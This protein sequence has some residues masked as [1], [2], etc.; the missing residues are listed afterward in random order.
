MVFAILSIKPQRYSTFNF[1]SGQPANGSNSTQASN[2]NYLSDLIKGSLRLFVGPAGLVLNG[3]SYS[4][5]AIEVR[6]KDNGQLGVFATKNFK[7]GEIITI[8]AGDVITRKQLAKLP[9]NL[10]TNALQVAPNLYIAAS[11]NPK[12][13][14]ANSDPAEHYNHSCDPNAFITGNNILYARRT[15]GAGEEIRFDYGTTDSGDNPDG[16]WKCDCGAPNCRGSSRPGSLLNLASAY[17]LQNMSRYLAKQAL[18][19]S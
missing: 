10:Q 3:S 6:R 14:T 16:N 17:G 15:I 1:T 4:S 8:F 9:P 5:P 11:A 12:D 2:T 18:S 7:P 19:S 13:Y